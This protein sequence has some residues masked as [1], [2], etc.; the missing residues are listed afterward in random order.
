MHQRFFVHGEYGSVGLQIDAL[1]APHYLQTPH[2]DV[3]DIAQAQSNQV[4][5]AT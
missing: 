5:H 4:Q 1:R 2:C 3:G